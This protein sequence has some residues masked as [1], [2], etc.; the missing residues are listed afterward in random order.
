MYKE[1]SLPL[2]VDP[3]FDDGY[4]ISMDREEI[5]RYK[6]EKHAIHIMNYLLAQRNHYMFDNVKDISSII[7][8]IPSDELVRQ[9]P[10]E[11]LLDHIPV[12]KEK[13]EADND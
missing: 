9:T 7:I 5:G 1:F 3:Y 11:N 2:E 4:V 6:E 12:V 8:S 10:D 13:T